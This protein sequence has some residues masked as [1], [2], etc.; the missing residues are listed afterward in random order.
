[1]ENQLDVLS[2]SGLLSQFRVMVTA[3][4]SLLSFPRHKYLRYILC[5]VI[6]DEVE[7]E[8]LSNKMPLIGY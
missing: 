8:E 5:K 2:N 1:M 6:G 4:R 3:S 7:K